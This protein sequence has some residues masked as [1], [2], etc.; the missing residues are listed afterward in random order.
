MTRKTFDLILT[1][2]GA[3]LVVVLIVAGSLAAWGAHFSDSNVHNQLAEQQI[4]FPSKTA[5]THPTGK[6]VRSTMDPYLEQYAGQQ[7][8]TGAQAEAYADHFIAIHLS[9]MPYDGV[10][11]KAS[12][13]SLKAPTTAKLAGVVQTSFKGTTLRGLL[14]EA[15]AFS[16]FG[17][18]AGVAAVCCFVLAGITLIFVLLGLWHLRRDTTT[19][20]V[21]EPKRMKSDLMKV[22]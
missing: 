12:A 16:V 19:E 6:E 20:M 2:V 3:M 1:S 21:L 8:L 14:L 18:I 9:E 10:Y 5:F 15:Y 17:H 7:L 22:D 4:Y 11:S 13:A